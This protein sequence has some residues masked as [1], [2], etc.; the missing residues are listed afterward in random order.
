[1][2]LTGSAL[3]SDVVRGDNQSIPIPL[4]TPE[5]RYQDYFNKVRERIKSKWVY[6]REAGERNIEGELLIEFHIAKDGHLEFIA[7]RQTSGTRV[8]DDAALTAVK[9]AQPFPPIPD[10]LAKE[11]LSINGAFRYQIVGGLANQS[12]R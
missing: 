11:T 7:L 8:L 3:T 10:G 1:M 4:D 9:L 6:P 12:L 5:P 2:E